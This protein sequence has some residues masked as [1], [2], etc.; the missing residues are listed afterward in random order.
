MKKENSSARKAHENL[1]K[2][3]YLN[4]T[5]ENLEKVFQNV[6]ESDDDFLIEEFIQLCSLSADKPKF[7]SY[8]LRIVQKYKMFGVKY[9]DE[10]VGYKNCRKI[11]ETY[12]DEIEKVVKE[13]K[14]ASE[15]N[16][17]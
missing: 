14:S 7:E 10:L 2:V 1:M 4:S 16:F 17:K 8:I 11:I 13:E 6:W 3:F 15:L 12:F 9:Y 5:P